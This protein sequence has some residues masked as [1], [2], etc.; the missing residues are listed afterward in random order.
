MNPM[1]ATVD[2]RLLMSRF[3]GR[4][5]CHKFIKKSTNENFGQKQ[6]EN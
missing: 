3:A 1:D 2:L 4:G 6:N 5:R